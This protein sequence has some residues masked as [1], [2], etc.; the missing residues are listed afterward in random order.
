MPVVTLPS[1]V[2]SK[3]YNLTVDKKDYES[4]IQSLSQHQQPATATIVPT[5]YNMNSEDSA[6]S[7]SLLNYGHSK[8]SKRYGSACR[9]SSGLTPS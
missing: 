8:T 6:T 2:S 9:D 3:F 5:A 7:L 1:L 4:N